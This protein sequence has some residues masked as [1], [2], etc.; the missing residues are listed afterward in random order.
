MPVAKSD[1][2]RFRAF[3]L[4]VKVFDEDIVVRAVLHFRE[5]DLC[6]PLTHVVDV[7]KLG[8]SGGEAAFDHLREGVGGVDAC[9]A[10]NAELHRPAMKSREIADRVVFDRSGIDDIAQSA[11]F[12]EL[13]YVV[14]FGRVADRLNAYSEAFDRLRS[15]RRR[16]KLHSEVVKFPRK[17]EDVVAVTLL[18]ADEHALAS[19]LKRFGNLEAR[20][21]EAFEHRFGKRFPDPENFAGRLHFG[22][23]DRVRVVELLERE[24]RDLDG[25]IRRCT[26]KPDAVAEIFQL[27]AEH[28]LRRE[29]D[30]R[31]A[32]DL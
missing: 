28:D 24:D 5:F 21:S 19:A 14:R 31:H 13:D 30:H 22:S 6:P 25:K 17:V 20:R 15:A 32:G 2:E 10:G 12:H 11:A 4:S 1:A 9:Q 29:L 27:F 23:E 7:N 3:D 8:V 16:E 18:N 26:V